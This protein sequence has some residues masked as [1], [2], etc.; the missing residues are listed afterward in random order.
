MA[1]GVYERWDSDLD[2]GVRGTGAG[3]KDTGA[4]STDVT[5]SERD[6]DED[7]EEATRKSKVADYR[8]RERGLAERSQAGYKKDKQVEKGKGM[9]DDGEWLIIDKCNDNGMFRFYFPHRDVISR[10][11]PNRI[12][13]F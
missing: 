6:E 7:T 3:S 2:G 1:R 4:S 5:A 11:D 13:R 8:G 10:A 9:E 12:V